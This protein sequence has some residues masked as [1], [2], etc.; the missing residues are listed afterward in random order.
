MDIPIAPFI[1]SPGSDISAEFEDLPSGAVVGDEVTVSIIVRSTFPSKVTPSYSLEVINKNEGR[2]L[3]KE[4]DNLQFGGA[5]TS[6]TGSLSVEKTSKRRLA[7][8]FTMPESDVRIKFKINADGKYPEEKQLYNNVLDSDPLAV[9]LV[10]PQSLPYDMLS[11]KVRVKLPS[12][13]AT[14]SLPGLPDAKW[15]GPA[16]GSLEVYNRTEDLLRDFE[17]L[18]NP[19]VN[20]E[21][22][23]ITRS[24][25]VTYTIKREDFGDDPLNKNWLNLKNPDEP[26]SRTGE[27]F[28]MGSVSRPYEYKRYWQEC[29]IVEG[30]EVCTT[31][32]ETLSG[33]A[34]AK[35]NS[36]SVFNPYDM[37][38][39]NGMKELPKQD[40]KKM[41]EN[42]SG[43]SRSKTMYWV[44]KPIPFE[45]IRWMHH[46]DEQGN[47]GNWA[48]VPGQYPREF[49]QQ[50]SAKINYNVASSMDNEYGQARDAAAKKKN[51][52]PQYDKAVFATDRDLQKYDYPIKSGY[53]FNPAGSYTFTVKTV[54]FKDKDP[55][56]KVTDDH[57]DLV[58]ALIDSFRYETD[59]M[60]INNNKDAVNIHNEQ[61]TP[62]GGGFVRQ[63]GVLSVQDNKGVNEV[64]LLQVVDGTK[65]PSKYTQKV[66]EVKSTDKR[67]GDSDKFWKMMM[68][69]YS[70]SGT[71]SSNTKYNYREYVKVGQHIYK[72][73]ET[74]EV[75]INVNPFNI[76]L[77]TH[78]NM[79]NGNYSIKVWFDDTK[80]TG[81]KHMYSNLDL[82]KGIADMDSINVTVVG[83]MFDDLNN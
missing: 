71:G 43:N 72:I 12:N 16:T 60:F 30:K 19:K 8:S 34:T 2:A 67:G 42:N 82:L 23:S 73:T 59:L 5:I 44:N 58:N 39:Y 66:E 41:I 78:A 65:D 77:Y 45:V 56:G 27:I 38:V 33:T 54:V 50:E 22:E 35:F 63:K 76:P 14:L 64:E 24:P 75:T 29:P 28:Y 6:A 53:Y 79:P 70:D 47:K 83:S 10:T 3:T 69:G 46:Q 31:H 62:K 18:N 15:T 51:V 36:D 68:E 32:S 25:I 13:T 1:N 61:L 9:K 7:V 55:G 4:K 81:M 80:L 48:Q 57:R 21:S 17:V 11:K 74:T 26:L 52:K 49:I 20:E 40:F 37:Y